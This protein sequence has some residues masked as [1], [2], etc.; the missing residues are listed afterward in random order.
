MG[1]VVK[2][3]GA[4]LDYEIDHA[5]ELADGDTIST[6]TWAATP[7][8]LTFTG[9]AIAGSIVSAF[10]EGGDHGELF[11]VINTAT[12]AAGRVIEYEITLRIVE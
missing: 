9:E 2:R 5:A 10:I 1:H 12:T 4:K 3:A 11:A 7:A 8:G 6:G